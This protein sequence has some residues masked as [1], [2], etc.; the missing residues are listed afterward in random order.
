MN[1]AVKPDSPHTRKRRRKTRTKNVSHLPAIITS[2]LKVNEIDLT[3]GKE[4]LVCPDCETW[5]P[6]TGALGN[7]PKLVPHHTV[8]ARVRTATPLRCTSSNR[9]VDLIETSTWRTGLGEALPTTTSRR[10]TKVLPKPKTA[11]AP[12]TSQLKPAPVSAETA[13]QALLRHTHRCPACAETARERADRSSNAEPALRCLDGERLAADF[14][15]LFRQEPRRRVVRDI[16]TRERRRFDR[17]YA[18]AAPAKRTSEW[19]AVLPA[20]AGADEQRV[21]DELT[22]TLRQLHPKLNR[23][24]KADLDNRLIRLTRALYQPKPR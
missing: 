15:R 10:A 17:Q 6:I 19:T 1:T 18:A 2:E 23:F 11:T 16:L 20:V 5:V 7:T 3:P 8:S 21:R 12:A 14:L 22:A 24:Q 9:P 4:H 13:R